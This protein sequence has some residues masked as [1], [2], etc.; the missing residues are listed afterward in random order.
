VAVQALFLVGI[1]S[2]DAGK[3][4]PSYVTKTAARDRFCYIRRLERNHA[5]LRLGV[6]RND[7]TSRFYVL[8]AGSDSAM[9]R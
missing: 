9:V 7:V 1:F 4:P 8:G 3:P 6:I 5:S 2:A